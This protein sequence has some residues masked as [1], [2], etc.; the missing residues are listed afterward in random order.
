MR[1]YFSDLFLPPGSRRRNL[2]IL[3]RKSVKILFN[4]GFGEL[5]RQ[6]KEHEEVR[7]REKNN[8]GMSDRD[9]VQT[10]LNRFRKS[11]ISGLKFPKPTKETEISLI[12]PVHNQFRYTVDC[13]NSVL[14]TTTGN[15]EVIVV[16]DAST[17]QTRS[18]LGTVPNL[19]L[20]RN[21]NNQGFVTSCN[22]G[23]KASKGRYLLF[24]NNDTMVTEHWLPPMLDLIKKDDVG[25]VGTKLVYPD[26]KLQEAGGIIWNDASG[27]NYGRGD[28]PGKPGY[29]FVR[30][31]DYCSGA[32]LLVKRDLFEK[33]GGF[34]ERYIPAYYE[35]ADLCFSIRKAG[36]KVLYQ[37]ASIVIHFEGI[38]SGKDVTSG[39][40]QYQV[41][42]KEKFYDKWKD[43]LQKEHFSKGLHNVFRA[44]SRASGKNVLVLDRHVPLFDRDA[45]S[46]RMFNILK[47]LGELGHKVTFLGDNLRP[48]APYDMVLQQSG[49]EVLSAPYIDSVEQYL[50]QFGGYFE[51]VIVSRLETARKNIEHIRKYCT[52]AKIIF[53]TV[54]LQSLRQSRMA[55]MTSDPD[56]L[57]KAEITKT[58]ELKVSRS[59]DIT[60]VVSPVEREIL[61]GEDPSLDVRIVSLIH[62]VV[63]PAKKFSERKDLLFVGSFLHHPNTDGVLWF[64]RDIFPR[65]KQQKPD[66]RFFIVGERP[67]E[68]IL[69][70]ASEDIMVT[71]YVRDL[72]GYFEKCRVFVAPLRFGAGVKGKINQS[73]SRGLPVVTTTIGSEGTG[74]IDGKNILVADDPRMFSE[75]VIRL[76]ENEQLWNMISENSLEHIKTTTSYERSKAR[77]KE[78][79]ETL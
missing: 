3:W 74:S 63:A 58:H 26:G 41:I 10:T 40:K 70:F 48:C 51:V 54:D 50:S 46:D 12:I 56:L 5:L 67:P 44:R 47:I 60:L 76:Y 43:I 32:A 17:D 45:G 19:T 21:D 11:N 2:F 62:S 69:S 9:K 20:I 52:N 4:E 59:S 37:P 66:I 23:V 39:V 1:Q 7:K 38:S 49:I 34:D 27:L 79:F 8:S 65:I 29:N 55:E 15:Y 6:F 33:I 42:N 14:H 18:R 16:D 35:D 71:G 73:M 78:L 53:D 64:I 72:T 75:D 13:L 77:I 61:K 22:K 57:A 36:Y 31:V 24:L 68:E 28:N 30:E 25:A